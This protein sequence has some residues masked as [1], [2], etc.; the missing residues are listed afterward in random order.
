MGKSLEKQLEDLSQEESGI[1][2]KIAER[3]KK[4]SIDCEGC[5]KSHQIQDL[6]LIQTHLYVSPRG[7][8]EGDYWN[9]G[10]MQFICP[11]TEIINRMLFNNHDVHWEERKKYANN[12][13]EQFRRNYKPLFKEVRE[14]YE[15]SKFRT[16]DNTYVDKNR[17]K[18]GLVKKRD[19]LLLV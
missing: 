5:S 16:V 9:E 2:K 17:G 8:T 19:E 18:F 13:E 15:E 6:T 7:C 10:E 1:L 4:K 14:V 3:N 11:E 12:S